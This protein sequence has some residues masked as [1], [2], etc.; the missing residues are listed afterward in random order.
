MLSKINAQHLQHFLRLRGHELPAGFVPGEFLAVQQNRPV[1]ETGQLKGTAAA[2]NS[3]TSYY[4]IRLLH[5]RLLTCLG[6]TTE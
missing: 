1:P 4:D 3:R 5:H 2:G 6:I